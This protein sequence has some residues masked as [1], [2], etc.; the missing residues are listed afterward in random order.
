MNQVGEDWNTPAGK[1]IVWRMRSP[2]TIPLLAQLIEDSESNTYP[3]RL[4]Y[5]RAFDFHSDPA[6]E[7]VLAQLA[8]NQHP[9][10]EEISMLALNHLS[11]NTVKNSPRLRTALKQSVEKTAGSKEYIELIKKYE[12]KEYTDDLMA[13]ALQMPEEELGAEAARLLLHLDQDKALHQ[14]MEQGAREDRKNMITALK[15]VNNGESHDLLEYVIRDMDQPID[16]RETAVMAFA[17]SWGGENRLLDMVRSGNLH[18]D[19][20]SVAALVFSRAM[21]NSI[22]EEAAALMELPGQSQ[23][24]ELPAIKELVAMRGNPE[25]G[26]TVFARACQNC[27]VV[28]GQGIDYGPGLSEIGDKLSR[29]ALY[30][31]ILH[32][33]EGISFGYEGYTVELTD[34]STVTGYILSKTEDEL[35]LRMY[36]GMTNTYPMSEVARVEQMEQSLMFD[37]LERSMTQQELVDLVE[38]LTTLRNAQTADNK[39]G[40]ALSLK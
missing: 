11:S 31:S 8:V 13:M 26:V 27:H 18:A 35:K 10:Q 20:D 1:D 2:E 37:N 29:D 17:N 3:E 15:R 24:G 39:A 9:Q 30:K 19:L 34:G 40:K 21:R 14:L 22:Y 28:N 7:Q 38:Y 6:K 36:G 5:F 4:R 23:E 25:N 32:P 12:L 33:S 16:V